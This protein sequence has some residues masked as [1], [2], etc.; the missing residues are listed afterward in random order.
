MIKKLIRQFKKHTLRNSILTLISIGA[1]FLGIFAIWFSTIEIPDLR[2][3]QDRKVAQSTKIFDRTGQILLY[4]V[5]ANAKRTLVTFENISDYIKNGVVA[6]E[7]T[8]FYEHKGIKPTA[9][10]RAVLANITSAGYSQG[11]ST[12]TQQVVKMTVLTNDKTIT[13]KL[14]EWILALKLER[15]LTKKEILTTYLNEAPYGGS[16]YGIEEASRQFFGKPAKDV[17]I[18][19]ASYLAAI[20]QAPTFYSPFGK[21]RDK[22]DARQKM[23]LKKMLDN[24]YITQKEYDDALKTKVV[25]LT[26]TEGNIKAPHFSLF[27]RDYLIDKYGEEK[28]M[29]GGLKVTTTLDYKLQAKAEEV[30]KNFAPALEANFSA[31]NTA[32]VA[33][34][35]KNGD[36]LMMVG[37]KDYFDVKIDGNVNITTSLRQ[38][39]SVFKPFVY[40]AAWEKGYTPETVLFDIDTEFSS[41]CNPDGTLKNKNYAKNKGVTEEEAKKEIC[42]SPQNYDDLFEGPMTMKKALAHSRNIPA[43]KTLYLA[44]TSNSL[45]LARTMGIS[46]LG[47]PNRYGLT[48][49]LGGGEVT[50]L[51]MT[52]A[53]GVFANEGMRVDKKFILKVEDYDGTILEE[54][55]ISNPERVMTENT[56]RQ[57]SDALSD[58]K[59]RL[60]SINQYL[61]D[62]PHDIAVK[63]GT[64]NDY[65]DVW[66]L[67]Y[68]PDIVV[69]AW[70]GKNDNT[71][72][73]KKVAGVIITP[74]W[75]TYINEILKDYPLNRFNSPE[76]TPKD[77][78][79]VLRGVWQGNI[80][81]VID[82]ISSK[83]AT[84]YTPEQT[85]VEQVFNNVH[86]ILY[87]I[88][89]D[90]PRGEAPTDKERIV[91]N[92][93][94]NWEFAVRK[95][96]DKWKIENPKFV[97]TTTYNI[98]TEKDNVHIPANFPKVSISL[99]S[100]LDFEYPKDENIKLSISASGKYAI[101]KTEIFINNN[102][103][104]SQ[105]G[106][107]SEFVFKPKDIDSLKD[108]NSITVIVYDSVYSSTKSSLNFAV[109]K[110]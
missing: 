83:I 70:A 71:S 109:S 21:N 16:I 40:A 59:V 78:P 72:M 7:D 62:N 100:G 79:P 46:S 28:V 86:S 26:K 104:N 76:D 82:K 22:L 14:K 41:E 48:L 75:A 96:F 50:L 97:E 67:G 20:P 66:I 80:S 73:G 42:Y 15:V 103:I 24:N 74:V 93:Y 52:S 55:E 19:E 5:H 102:F 92:Q 4:D 38:P 1:I 69:G 6:I 58:R 65:K 60:D 63:T 61:G 27:I 37:S 89:K 101:T 35:P 90:D 99:D 95:W 81:Y 107:L 11:G 12:I 77:I 45:K 49:V 34:D 18:A 98:P 88:E 9:I 3:F 85:R 25:F 110:E 23:V 47:D 31:S 64:T 13:R 43:V 68:T 2:A 53:Y 10:L 30:V 29:N 54:S 57:I 36:V 44:G 94:A 8:E 87:W 105:D 56:A 33:I 106:P 32:M 39:G 91:D 51:D 84:E 17:T 108:K